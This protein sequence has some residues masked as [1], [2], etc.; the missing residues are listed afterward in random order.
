MDPWLLLL[1]AEEYCTP[2]WRGYE[3]RGLHPLQ[4]VKKE[5]AGYSQDNG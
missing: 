3:G 2:L 4:T 1:C 5:C